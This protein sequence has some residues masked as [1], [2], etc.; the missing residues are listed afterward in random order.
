MNALNLSHYLIILQNLQLVAWCC[1]A[2]ILHGTENAFRLASCSVGRTGC[3]SILHHHVNSTLAACLINS[4]I[5][6]QVHQKIGHYVIAAVRF[7]LFH[8]FE[9]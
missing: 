2:S 7:S 9:Y 1:A 8:L 3:N 6:R 5:V 4:R